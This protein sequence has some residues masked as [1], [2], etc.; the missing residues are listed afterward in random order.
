MALRYDSIVSQF[1]SGFCSMRTQFILAAACAAMASQALAHGPQ[2]QITVD[3]G[4]LTTRHV[5]TNVYTPLTDEKRVYAMPV[6]LVEDFDFGPSWRARPESNPAYPFGPGAAFGLG[7][8]LPT[9][10]TLTL[11]FLSELQLWDGSSF[12]SAG[13]TELAALR[14]GNP[15]PNSLTG[16]AAFSGGPDFTAE[17]NIG[18]TYS[19]S[20]HGSVTYVFLGDGVSPTAPVADGVYLATMGWSSSD[21]LIAPSDPFYLVLNK[22]SATELMSAISSLGFA[23][24]AVQY[25]A[26]P[27]PSAFVLAILGLMTASRRTRS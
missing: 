22:G 6:S 19:E 25:L 18:A 20:S 10:S 1:T 7:A 12:V 8:T 21:P 5:L 15:G 13:A 24:A 23:P 16:N 14:T 4:K 26:I 2:M 9:S 11:S 3:G 17:V 27:E